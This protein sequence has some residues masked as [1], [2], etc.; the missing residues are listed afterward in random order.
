MGAYLSGHFFILHQADSAEG[1]DTLDIESPFSLFA[2]AL[3]ISTEA[4]L[5]T[6]PYG[7]NFMPLFGSMEIQLAIFLAVPVIYGQ[8][9]RI[10]ILPSKESTPLLAFRNTSRI[11]SSVICCLKRL[12]F[13]NIIISPLSYTKNAISL[14]SLT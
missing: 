12:I 13:L 7:L 14:S 3:I 8:P 5:I 10:A 6:V 2:V 11:S 4:C 9:I 1:N